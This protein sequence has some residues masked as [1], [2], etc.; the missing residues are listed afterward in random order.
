MVVAAVVGEL[1][2]EV[3]VAVVVVADEMI[4]AVANF[5][6]VF[7]VFLLSWENVR[8]REQEIERKKDRWRKEQEEKVERNFGVGNKLQKTGLLL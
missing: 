1:A 2:D 4:V 5:A 8:E 3:V 7:V 6:L